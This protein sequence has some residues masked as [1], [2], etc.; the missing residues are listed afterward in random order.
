MLHQ[1]SLPLLTI[2]V[3]HPQGHRPLHPCLQTGKE[4]V[5]MRL[6]ASA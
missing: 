3:P 4:G 2:T 1:L 6:I 5:E